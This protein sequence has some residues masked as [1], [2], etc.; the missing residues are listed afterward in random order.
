MVYRDP[1]SEY[2]S[3]TISGIVF[4]WMAQYEIQDHELFMRV[5]GNTTNRPSNDF[6]RNISYGREFAYIPR[7]SFCRYLQVKT[8]FSYVD[9]NY[10]REK[11]CSPA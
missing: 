1:V 3:S 5:K 11:N 7:N 9:T 6:R 10:F 4:F 2:N 8:N